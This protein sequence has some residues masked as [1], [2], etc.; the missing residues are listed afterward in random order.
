VKFPTGGRARE[1]F[2]SPQTVSMD[3]VEFQGRQS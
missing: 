3:L 1:Y 2:P